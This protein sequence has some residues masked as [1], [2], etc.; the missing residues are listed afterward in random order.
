MKNFALAIGATFFWLI[1][2]EVA[3]RLVYN[4]AHLSISNAIMGE[5]M[6]RYDDQL[7]WKIIPNSNGEY[8]ASRPIRYSHNSLGMRETEI[9]EDSRKRILFL[10]D[11]F[12]WGFDVEQD[13]RFTELL[14]PHFEDYQLINAG[15]NGYGTD[16]QW[17]WFNHLESIIKPDVV[18]L[19]YFGEND[20]VDNSTNL[21]HGGFYKPYFEKSDDMLTIKGTP[22]PKGERY[23]YAENPTLSKSW[24]VRLAASAWFKNKAPAQ[25]YVEDPTFDILQKFN[26][27]LL[28]KQIPFLLI[29]QSPKESVKTFS[30]A[31]NIP[32]L[33]VSNDYRYETFGG[34]WTPEGHQFVA[35]SML[36]FLITHLE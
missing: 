7:G 28:S 11:S 9:I 8:T 2:A 30:E 26:D 20:H 15:I 12:T 19:L 34:H 1:I 36:N 32:F 17:L 14:K 35:D 27:H 10:G 29:A 18:V 5:P 22:V 16:Q 25:V 33:D 13:E 3:L 31:H 21:R 4:P 23:F 24:L 6:F